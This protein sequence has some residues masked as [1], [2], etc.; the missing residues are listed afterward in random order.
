MKILILGL[1]NIGSALA[2]KWRGQGHH[3]TGTTTTEAK[4]TGLREIADEV[5]VL[6]GS[7]TAAIAQAASGKDAVV[8][9]VAPSVRKARTPEE[10]TTAYRE[11]LVATCVSAAA[12]HPRCI[13]LSSFSVYAEGPQGD[14]PIVEDDPLPDSAEP[15]TVNYR[16]AE[17]AVLANGQGS[18]L[19]LPDMYGAPG[20]TTLVERVRLGI[21]F[22]GGRVPFGRD[23]LFHRIHFEDVVSAV[24][25]VVR[26]GLTGALNVCDEET[27]PPTNAA[28]FDSICDEK[29]WPRLTFL[30]QIKA[31][32]RRISAARMYA[33]G[34]RADHHGI[35]S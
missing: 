10:R 11:A 30:D 25:H 24:D 4:V 19:R 13:F 22:M 23:A 21:D 35:G 1:G 8:I 33:T 17:L 2:R 29:G 14:A 18:A 3:V 20:D 31:P 27:L 15:S 26:H 12:A 34:W 32:R 9:T 7:D 16:A 28:V 5:L 6:R